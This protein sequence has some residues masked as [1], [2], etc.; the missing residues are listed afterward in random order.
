MKSVL[1]ML[2][3]SLCWFTTGYCIASIVRLQRVKKLVRGMDVKSAN[4]SVELKKFEIQLETLQN[5][6]YFLL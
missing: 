1:F 4:D 3:F 2:L 6:N 5:F